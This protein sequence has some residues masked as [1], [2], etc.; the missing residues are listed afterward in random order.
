MNMQSNAIQ[1]SFALE[2]H[3]LQRIRRIIVA[4]SLLIGVILLIRVIV[5]RWNELQSTHENTLTTIS[6]NIERDVVEIFDDLRTTAQ[7]DAIKQEQ[8]LAEYAVI[9]SDLLKLRIT[10]F[11]SARRLDTGGSTQV[12]VNNDNGTIQISRGTEFIGVFRDPGYPRALGSA[13]GE[14]SIGNFQLRTQSDGTLVEPAHLVLN[15]Y[16]PI[17]D[18]NSVSNVIGVLQLTIDATNILQTIN[19]ITNQLTNFTDSTRVILFDDQSNVI[20][21]STATTDLY[22]QN[23]TIAGSNITLD[24][25]YEKLSENII[26]AG[27]YNLEIQGPDL[28]SSQTIQFGEKT[29]H[30]FYVNN[31]TPII[32]SIFRSVIP[33]WIALIIITVVVLWFIRNTLQQNL[34]PITQATSLAQ[35]IA[36]GGTLTTTSSNGVK[37]HNLLQSIE[38]ISRQLVDFRT[39]VEQQNAKHLGE[40]QTIHD[41]GRTIASLTKLDSLL[42]QSVTLI[43]QK[44]SIDNAQIFFVNDT[45]EEI[46][47]VQTSHPD[48]HRAYSLAIATHT[49][50]GT[51]ARNR[52]PLIV[53]NTLQHTYQIID[54]IL[55]ETR[56]QA[57]Y[58]LLVG[59]TLIGVLDLQNNQSNTFQQA[60]NYQFQLLADQLAIAI[61]NIRTLQQ[62]QKQLAEIEQLNRQIT[63][64]AWDVAQERLAFEPSYKY[65]LLEVEEGIP[66]EEIKDISTPIRIGGEI[67]GQLRVSPPNDRSID[68][69]DE[70]VLQAVAERVAFAMENQ[71]LF[72]EAESERN[73]L[74]N[75]LSTMPVGV[76]VLNAATLY[77]ILFNQR[78][79]ELLH[80]PIDTEQPFTIE[81]YQFYRTGTNNLYP[82]E[83]LPTSLV[84][85]GQK[86]A[87]GEDITI[88][89]DDREI[90][91][92]MNATGIQN[93]SGQTNSIIVTLQDVSPLRQLENT[94]QDNLQSMITLYNAQQDFAQADTLDSVLDTVHMQLMLLEVMD[95]YLIL[96]NETNDLQV[97][98]YTIEPLE[99][100]NRYRSL[101]ASIQNEA[102]IIDDIE[103]D[104]RI[105]EVI[106]KQFKNR[107][108]QSVYIAT[109]RPRQ[110]ESS[111]GWIMLVDEDKHH[112]NDE[113]R[114][115]LLNS[116][117][118]MTTVALENQYLIQRTQATLHE[119]DLLYTATNRIN[120]ASSIQELAQ[121]LQESL[122]AA[123]SPDMYAGYAPNEQ[124]EIIELFSVGF[125]EGDSF[126]NLLPYNLPLDDGV[127]ISDITRTTISGLG[128]ELLKNNSFSAFAAVTLRTKNTNKGRLFIAYTEQHTFT[129]SEVRFLN[130]I[131]DSASVVLDNQILVEETQKSLTEI[132]IQYQAGREL[133]KTDDPRDISDIII[134]F[135]MEPHINHLFLALLNGDSWDQPGASMHIVSNWHI[136]DAIDFQDVTFTADDLPLWSLLA[137][138]EIRV[139]ED[140]YAE[141][142]DLDPMEIGGLESLEARS[143]TIVPLQ[144]NRRALGVIWMSSR[145]T[146]LYN[147]KS[148]RTLSSFG[149]QASLKLETDRLLRQT[150]RR[151]RQLQTSAL[152]SRQA[153]QIASLDVLLPQLV[154]LIQEQFSY[155]HVQI[156]LMDD[157]DDFAELQ[158]STGRAG[159]QLL[160]NRHKLQK[161]SMSVIGQ[162]TATGEPAIALDTT[163]TD[164]VHKPNPLLPNTRSEMALPLILKGEVIGALDVQS[165][166]ANA[167]DLEDIE[168]LTTLAAQISVA[169]DNARLYDVTQKRANEMAFLFDVT[170]V[171][172]TSDN[173]DFALQGVADR[174][175]ETL[176]SEVIVIYIPQEYRDH[177]DNVLTTLKPIA[178]SGSD[179]PI[180]EITE[181]PEGDSENILSM[182]MDS[183][184][185]MI[186]PNIDKEV[187]Y[188]PIDPMSKSALI[189]P[190]NNGME[191]IGLI[192]SED[193]HP[194]AYTYDTLQ[195]IITMTS[196][197]TTVIQN[198][199]LVEQLQATN[200][201]LREVDRLKSE[202]L[203]NMSHELRTPLNS[204]IG[205]SR[206]MLKGIDGPITETQE[207]DLNT[208]YNSG[209]HL[210]RLINDILDQAKIAANKMDLKFAYFDSKAMIESVKSIGIGLLKEKPVNLFVEIEPNIPDVYGDEFRTRQILLNL[211]NNAS[212]FTMEGS[213]TIRVYTKVDEHSRGLKMVRVD[214][215]DTG[216]GIAEKDMP[217][218][219]EAFQQ[220]DSSLTRVAGGT[221]LGL[222]I[223]KSLAETQGGALIVESEVNVGSIFSV[224]I[225][226]NEIEGVHE[227]EPTEVE[228]DSS[229]ESLV[230]KEPKP[231]LPASEPQTGKLI[232]PRMALL[233]EDDK[234]MV[235]Q[236]RR[237]LQNEGFGVVTADHISYAETMASNI[238]P[239]VILLD[240]AFAENQGLEL[241]EKL[242]TREDTM[243]IPVIVVALT[244]QAE[245]A[246]NLGAYKFIQR[247]F[248]P[249]DLLGVVLDA[250]KESNIGRILIIDDEPESIRLIQQVLDENGEYKIFTASNGAE[251]VGMIARRSPDLVILDLRM[252]EA[253]GFKVLQDLQMNPETSKI[254]VVII[255]GESLNDEEE[256]QLENIPVLQKTDLGQAQY[257]DFLENIN[258]YLVM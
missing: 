37:D 119:T 184:Q 197:L 28:I 7:L 221:G 110:Q 89:A 239:T 104:S 21:D 134:N 117:R 139:V 35:Q 222:P 33:F 208:I 253:D 64:E 229:V 252:P 59:D 201:Q 164:V 144:V 230:I 122:A 9:L 94:L 44:L 45:Q 227:Q 88:F 169:I 55:P 32:I 47:L 86:Q 251:G 74:Q 225:P 78:A 246:L 73:N 129:D 196:S 27:N 80:I 173:L 50:V 34:A 200:E 38:H 14:I 242:K 53:S 194:N 12:E 62:N 79:Q 181:I 101:F 154:E 138:S 65:N 128:R 113:D 166:L 146:T 186:I 243:D 156:F 183:F 109:L 142:V 175:Q 68:T 140:I 245:E 40:L 228:E 254:P 207:Q 72:T 42:Q 233:I 102:I 39:K 41:I 206:V 237:T 165:N 48:I 77:P 36:S 216:I 159:Q 121:V 5:T 157:D 185:S 171:A 67:I 52:S 69:G 223:A 29:W 244:D 232:R 188:L 158:A 99:K 178:L 70:M 107:G 15:L 257:D 209:Q 250:E 8:N 236:F 19:N 224:Y 130:A 172:T 143:V 111:F 3:I 71:R 93:A 118:D 191:L 249:E 127:Y 22:I 95:A 83:E 179:Q 124:G 106:R 16:T 170:T 125:D 17:Y 174:L 182:V 219:F 234:N 26:Q 87:L 204:I 212:K 137:T 98:R 49:V 25:L 190:F 76:I 220:V 85:N 116:L 60:D 160:A 258:K 13:N 203:A 92:F 84:V 217:R 177:H 149:E 238:R 46:T 108:I 180:S 136:D 6:V 187:R 115:N 215:I 1:Q 213:I 151:A 131:A 135:L 57:G 97:A 148:I 211:V 255:T 90:D 43:C 241:L 189:I 10:E 91:L 54:S 56:S 81:R 133:A 145:E 132:S 167:F 126:E 66:T 193:L 218:L 176:E 248:L 199:R 63:K 247:P 155:D 192:V 214:V 141:N 103:S 210:L 31:L 152:V 120:R 147:M 161:G 114:K 58:P 195:L 168:V 96:K 61:Q 226:I 198:I 153:A 11:V 20:A 231:S 24:P 51:V 123:L 23:I 235:D 240:A 205:F 100:L 2:Q 163:G 4:A 162:V 82:S 105:N 150:D 112:F 202:F 18:I 30:I 256:K 75:I